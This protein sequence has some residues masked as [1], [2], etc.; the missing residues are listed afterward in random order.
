MT[1]CSLCIATYNWPAALKACLQTVLQQRTLPGEVIIA[2]D[3]STAETEAVVA[4]FRQQLP[5]PVK[6]I[7]QPD[8]GFRLAQIRNKAFAAAQHPL[9][10]QIDGDLLLHPEFIADHQ[11]A[12]RRGTFIAG[13][14]VLVDQ[15]LSQALLDAEGNIFPPVFSRHVKKSYNG[16]RIPLL[17]AV[18]RYLQRG[19]NGY[20]YVLGCNMSFWKEDLLAVNGYN[21]SFTGWGKEDND[22][23][24][25]LVNA[26]VQL[27]FL[28]FGG[29]VYHLH[30]RKSDASAMN[31]NEEMLRRSLKNRVTYIEKG[32]HQYIQK[33]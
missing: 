8:E 7:W 10:V 13:S 19:G 9:V 33:P 21:E 26:G 27:R 30:H 12:A 3:G 6:H 2:D 32:M 25:R 22:I 4:A 16:V 17:S 14:R 24:I 5:V 23:A 20:K 1:S 18:N 11:R 31:R 15:Q 28:K 29:V